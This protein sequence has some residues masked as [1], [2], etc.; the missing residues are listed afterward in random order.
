MTPTG[1]FNV[2]L[3][4]REKFRP[5]RTPLCGQRPKVGW[6]H[7]VAFGV[8]RRLNPRLGAS[9]EHMRDRGQPGGVVE[10]TGT[11]IERF[12]TALPRA[13]N[14]G[15]AIDAEPGRNIRA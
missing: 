12:R 1:S 8:R 15:A 5:H 3:F 6:L 10:R 14:A 7:L 4:F 11:D 13:V 2:E 9:Q